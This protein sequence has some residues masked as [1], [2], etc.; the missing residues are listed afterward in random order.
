[1]NLKDLH[2]PFPH[3]SIHWRVGS[4]TKDKTRGMALAYLDA[5]DVM[6]RLDQVCGPENWSDSYTETHSGKTICTISIRIDEEWVSKADGAGD[7]DIEGVKGG[8]SDA[9][10][11]AAVK[12]GIGRYLY[13][14]QSPWVRLDKFKN[15]EKDEYAKLDAVLKGKDVPDTATK[16]DSRDTYMAITHALREGGTMD[17]IFELYQKNKETIQTMTPDWRRQVFIEYVK[18]MVGAAENM[19]AI[20]IFFNSIQKALAALDDEERAGI[21]QAVE[22]HRVF[23]KE[24][25]A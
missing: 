6:E 2:K 22:D 20:N 24:N 1:M 4:T 12:W 14:L 11:R 3:S 18:L 5:R 21:D 10:K 8:I 9:F 23:L 19:G 17:E 7:T 25:A 15:I 13:S 16:A